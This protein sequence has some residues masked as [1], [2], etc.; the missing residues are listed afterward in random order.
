MG[1]PAAFILQDGRIGIPKG[2][3]WDGCT[4]I[5]YIADIYFGTSDESVHPETE[6]PGTYYGC[7]F[8]DVLNEIIEGRPGFERPGH[9]S[10]LQPEG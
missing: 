1:L 10:D 4:L 7:L 8:Y 9:E 6:R 3:R 2:Y 5:I